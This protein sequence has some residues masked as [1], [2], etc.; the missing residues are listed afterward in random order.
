MYA[1]AKELVNKEVRTGTGDMS[2]TSN[3]SCLLNTEQ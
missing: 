3:L 2:F 1:G